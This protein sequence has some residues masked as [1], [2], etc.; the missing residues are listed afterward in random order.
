MVIAGALDTCPGNEMRKEASE[1]ARRIIIRE[2]VEKIAVRLGGG[3]PASLFFSFF[4]PFF[5]PR[6]GPRPVIAFT[7]NFNFRRVKD[8]LI[9]SAF[10]AEITSRRAQQETGVL[11]FVFGQ[12]TVNASFFFFLYL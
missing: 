2:A 11:E 12:Q 9:G 1:V 3:R 7:H 10:Y 5:F 6:R 8:S 4:F